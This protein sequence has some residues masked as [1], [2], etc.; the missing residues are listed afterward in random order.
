[1]APP[2]FPYQSNKEKPDQDNTPQDL[3]TTRWLPYSVCAKTV[4]S[5]QIKIR[6]RKPNQT[7]KKKTLRESA[8]SLTV[9]LSE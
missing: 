9:Y 2:P 4:A 3:T 1:M 8:V 7:N 6:D 5:S